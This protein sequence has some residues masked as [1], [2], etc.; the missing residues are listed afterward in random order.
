[1]RRRL[2]RRSRSGK[3][4][5]AALDVFAEEPL[6]DSPLLALP[7]VVLTPH[8]GAS[9]VEAQDKAGVDVAR[10]LALALRASWCSSAVNVDLGPEVADEVRAFLPLVEQLGRVFVALARGH[11]RSGVRCAPR[12]GSPTTRSGLSV[13]RRSRA[14]WRR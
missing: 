9:T 14:P 7:Q 12:D 8:L 6:G 1:M 13:W 11:P 5:G 3:V 10:S 2:P 4:A